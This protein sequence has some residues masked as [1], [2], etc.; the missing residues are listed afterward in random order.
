MA[1]WRTYAKAARNTA[2]KQAPA[3][4]DA[5]RRA[6]SRASGYV[7]A[8]GKAID[9]GRSE[10]EEP[11]RRADREREGAREEPRRRDAS[12]RDRE[13]R[14]HGDTDGA[15]EEPR[16]S[17]SSRPA[18]TTARERPAVDTSRL[19]KDAAAY[20]TVAERRVHSAQIVPRFMRALRDA[21]LIGLSL[22]VFW[23]VLAAAGIQIPF[24]T[25]LI[26]VLVIVAIS[27]A[28]GLLARR[29]S[30]AAPDDPAEDHGPG[31]A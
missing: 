4:G 27:F 14:R 6:S 13:P 31:P 3:A 25:V 23:I 21:L 29:R 26:V 7:R 24:T 22:F 19:R 20:Y 9:E 15:R 30:P 10:D 28:T 8:A 2:R 11:R 12:D 5:A 17:A 1:D 18:A 16:R